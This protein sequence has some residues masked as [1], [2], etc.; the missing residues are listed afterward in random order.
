MVEQNVVD[1]GVPVTAVDKTIKQQ[2]IKHHDI[3]T[4]LKQGF[5]RSE[6]DRSALATAMRLRR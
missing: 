6:A 1:G 4:K 5:A 2:G 3:E